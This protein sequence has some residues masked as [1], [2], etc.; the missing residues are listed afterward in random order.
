MPVI[1]H[2]RV[3]SGTGGGPEKTILNSPRF[4]RPFQYRS[5]CIY[6][7]DPE[8][9]G[10]AVLTERAAERN[11]PL[12]AIDDFGIK[13]WRITKRVS[14]LLEHYP[15]AIWHGHDYKSNLLGLLLRRRH[16][17]PLV[18]TV[19]GWVQRTWKTPLYYFIDRRCLPRY[20]Q[21]VCVSQDLYNDCVRLGVAESQL[22]LID[23][24]IALD[25]YKVDVSQSDAKRKIGFDADTF[26]IVA[27][28]R[29][30]AE[31]GFDLLIEAVASLIES[32]KNIGLAI[33]GDGSEDQ[34]L[35]Q[36]IKRTGYEQRIRLLGFVSD[37]R[38]VYR[39]ADLYTLSSRREGLPNVVLEAMAMNL[40]VVATR[41]A[42][43]PRLMRDGVNGRLVDPG[44]KESLS[45]AIAELIDD[46]IKR[47]Q[48]A[49]EGR[50]TIEES[51]SFKR[52][53][54]QMVDIYQSLSFAN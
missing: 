6:L 50:K 44:C 26:L 15:N 46:P 18:T 23:N 41:V 12:Q 4:L 42:G 5:V 43:M 54:E 38:Q 7:R 32:G 17:M 24:A 51:F 29:L 13:D 21:V 48:M 52:R 8:D 3:V 33:A 27:V 30:S 45:Q 9:S 2:V 34:Q 53:M 39:A 20:D 10:F 22:T 14:K 25:D 19:H 1:L 31:K 49:A 35:Q 16:P 36:Q 37:P 11:A 47:A 40:P 28:G